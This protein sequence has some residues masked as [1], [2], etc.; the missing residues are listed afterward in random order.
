MKVKYIL[1][2]EVD[3]NDTTP[4]KSRSELTIDDLIPNEADGEEMF[5][6]AVQYVM[7]FMVTHFKAF[8]HLKNKVF[9]LKLPHPVKKSEV[10]PLKIL[11]KDEKYT[12]AN[13][14]ILESFK[15]DAH[16]TCN[17]QVSLVPR[18]YLDNCIKGDL[19]H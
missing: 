10:A 9:P 11:D 1:S 19:I 18:P 14:E 6:R 2:R 8:A 15:K 5:V 3:W 4:Q 13:I 7:R 16:M 12:Q 17:P